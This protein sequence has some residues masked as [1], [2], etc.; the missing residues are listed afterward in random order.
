MKNIQKI[1]TNLIARGHVLS[2]HKIKIGGAVDVTV[3]P[4]TEAVQRSTHRYAMFVY[5]G[6]QSDDHFSGNPAFIAEQFVSLIG[7]DLARE[8]A[9]RIMIGHNLQPHHYGAKGLW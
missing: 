3:G 8:S 2:C 4:Y 7:R 6:N 5:R 1:V 9:R